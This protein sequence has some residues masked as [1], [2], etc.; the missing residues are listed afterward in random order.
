LESSYL[1]WGVVSLG[2]RFPTFRTIVLP[3][4]L[5]VFSSCPITS[6]QLDSNLN[7]LSPVT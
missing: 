1:E 6:P 4:S 5:S 3:S 2:E 7:Q